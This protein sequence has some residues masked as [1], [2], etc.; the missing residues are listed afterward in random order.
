MT[1]VVSSLAEFDSNSNTSIHGV[2]WGANEGLFVYRNAS[3]GIAEMRLVTN[4]SPP[5]VGS[6]ITLNSPNTV[7]ASRG[8]RIRLISSLKALLMISDNTGA[9]DILRCAIISGA[10]PSVSAFTTVEGLGSGNV[11]G[12]IAITDTSN[13]LAAWRTSAQL[14]IAD[15]NVSGATVTSVSARV[16]TGFGAKLP[17][18]M[19]GLDST[20]ALLCYD[21]SGAV[22]AAVVSLGPSVGAASSS[23]V[24]T[25]PSTNGGHNIALLSTDKSMFVVDDRSGAD[26]SDAYIINTSGTTISSVGTIFHPSN[27]FPVVLKRD[28]STVYIATGDTLTDKDIGTYAVDGSDIIT[29]D[30][31]PTVFDTGLDLTGDQVEID[32]DTVIVVFRDTSNTAMIQATNFTSFDFRHSAGGIP[33]SII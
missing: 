22:R 30:I 31:A 29:Q 2:P 25:S 8:V 33:G 16:S 26:E 27:A 6:A 15:M 24:T 28:A 7:G 20:R 9:N 18:D 14:Y 12:V 32:S 5:T 1:I 17:L 3:T 23:I 10:S 19:N 11:D 13:A 21:Q 4:G